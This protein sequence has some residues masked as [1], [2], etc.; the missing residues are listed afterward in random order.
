MY[1]TV[2]TVHTK[3]KA[4]KNDNNAEGKNAEGLDPA[5]NSL[6]GSEFFPRLGSEH[7]PTNRPEF[8]PGG[9]KPRQHV[10]F[11]SIEK[12]KGV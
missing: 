7:T 2:L 6:G 4:V 5:P 12:D 3:T 9:G 1:A 10:R 11:R 8:H